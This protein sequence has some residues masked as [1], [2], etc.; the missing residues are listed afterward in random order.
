MADGEAG[1]GSSLPMLIPVHAYRRNHPRS[2]ASSLPRR[3]GITPFGPGSG[4][5]PPAAMM[6]VCPFLLGAYRRVRG[7]VQRRLP[8]ALLA[9]CWQAGHAAR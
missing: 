3:R 6:L 8:W 5:P 2:F 1:G 7:L 9:R 4:G